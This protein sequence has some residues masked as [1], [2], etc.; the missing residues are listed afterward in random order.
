MGAWSQKGFL[1]AVAPASFHLLCQ[2]LSVRDCDLVRYPC[3]PHLAHAV[4]HCTIQPG[5]W[6]LG[7]P[8]P[9]AVSSFV[10]PQSSPSTVL[11]LMAS[12]MAQDRYSGGPGGSRWLGEQSGAFV[13]AWPVCSLPVLCRGD[14]WVSSSGT[15]EASR[16]TCLSLGIFPLWP[17]GPCLAQCP[18]PALHVHGV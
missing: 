17:S 12:Q 7:P 18:S 13:P 6:W 1:V 3:P 14:A 5:K 9:R 4:C 15:Q 2:S 10:P 8:C 11:W 16:G